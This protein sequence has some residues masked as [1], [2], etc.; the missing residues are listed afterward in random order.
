MGNVVGGVRSAKKSFL[1]DRGSGKRAA[2]CRRDA[3]RGL[4]W[5]KKPAQIDAATR[6]GRRLAQDN[7]AYSDMRGKCAGEGKFA[8]RVG[9]AGLAN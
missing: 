5:T 2:S 7:Q 3:E 8:P 9:K 1:A 6:G 4:I